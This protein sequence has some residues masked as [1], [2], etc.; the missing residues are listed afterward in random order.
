MSLYTLIADK[1]SEIFPLDVNRVKF[2]QENLPNNNS[3]IIDVGCATGDL[4][5]ELSKIGYFVTGIDLNEPMIK[6]AKEISKKNRYSSIFNVLDMFKI[7]TLNKADGILCFGNTLPHLKSV[8]EVGKFFKKVYNQLN[9]NGQFIF[10][11]LNYDKVIKENKIVFS[12]IESVDYKFTREYTSITNK[13]VKFKINYEDKNAKK[14]FSDT[15]NLLVLK[16]QDII[17]MLKKSGF[18]YINIYQDYSKK[19]S[20]GNEFSTIFHTMR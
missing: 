16:K 13:E 12:E 20:D 7:N 18:T 1:Y 4:S 9:I 19:P 15:T 6:I 17:N 3:V 8:S 11:I 2:I 5:N 14:I 10:Q